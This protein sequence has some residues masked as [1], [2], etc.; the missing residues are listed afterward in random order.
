MTPVSKDKKLASILVVSTDLPLDDMLSSILTEQGYHVELANTTNE[1]M[2]KT[3]QN[4]YDLVLLDLAAP[5]M[6]PLPTLESLTQ[7]FPRLPVVV[8]VYSHTELQQRVELIK[9]G[10]FD[11]L[12][13]P[14]QWHELKVV[15]QRTQVVIRLKGHAEKISRRLHKS[16]EYFKS[17]VQA[18]P[19][20]MVLGDEGGTILSWNEAAQH[21][22]GYTAKEIIGQP[23]TRLMP[24]RYHQAHQQG[25]AR[26]STT[27]NT[28]VIGHTVE[29]EALRR[30]G[31]EFP[32]ELSLSYSHVEDKIFY[33]GIIRDITERKEA[34]KALLERNRMLALDADV[35]QI[36]SR[37][38]EL[39]PLLQACAEA[40]LRHLDVAFARIW[41]LEHKEQVLA[42]KAS[43]GL[44]THL[45]GL[46]SR[47][48]IGYLK[49]GKIAAE[50]KPILTNSV[51]GDPRIPD[52]EWAK[53][54]EL[55]AFAGYPL[56]RGQE[57]VGVMALFAKHP[58]TEFTL[59]SLEMVADRITTAVEFQRATEVNQKL[60]N[61]NEQI[62]AS[63]GEGIFGLSPQGTITFV[64]PAGANML[65][66]QADEM[67]DLE[68]HTSIHPTNHEGASCLIEGCPL[69][70]VVT[71][72]ASQHDD[73]EVFCRKNG[74]SFPVEYTAT[75]MWEDG[76]VTG[77]VVIFKDISLRKLAEEAQERFCQQIGATLA[78]LPGSILVVDRAQK[79]LYAN[80]KAQQ[81]FGEHY[82]S[83]IGC[84]IHEVLPFTP[85]EWA[86]LEEEFSRRR[87]ADE[88]HLQDL[89]FEIGDRTYAYCLFPISLEGW[90]I[91]ET[92]IVIWNVTER[93][94]LQ[95]QLIQSEKLSSLG[96]LVS[97]MVHEV[98]SPMQSIVG[99]TDLI[100]QEEDPQ[101]IQEFAGDLKRV[102]AHINTVLTDFMTYARPSAH[103]Q[104]SEVNLN[105]R[106]SEALKMV[107]RGP[108]FGKVEVTQQFSS[109]P[110]VSVRQGEIDQ[111]LI[112]LMGN[113]VQAM[114]GKG[115]L[116]LATFHKDNL[117]TA[118]ISDTGCGMPKE[119]LHKIFDPFFSTKG[120]GKG[121]GLGLSIVQQIV[122]RCGGQI[123][124]ESE[125]GKG[126]TFTIQLPGSS[127]S[128]GGDMG[129]V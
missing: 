21:M 70:A 2:R 50:K 40:L 45:D 62:L 119:I 88:E 113:A 104:S 66:Y 82:P 56:L 4:G 89:E 67:R 97:G 100:L 116:T 61:F 35:G 112:N 105:E 26:V 27:H 126:T 91:S 99:Y 65:G 107:Q 111:V 52:Q 98:R 124:V 44:Y 108:T 58:L 57:V 121:T 46:H 29:L 14:Y 73:R 85:A 101:A 71:D 55:V 37:K 11:L 3:S 90:D 48:P 38:Q 19:D 76:Q 36:I 47:I 33:C 12:T 118:Q 102:C 92:G 125:V 122:K 127:I 23:L 60:A 32:I 17:V 69:L 74:T 110:S 115:R 117:V 109:L 123:S 75:P 95:D 22:F 87:N 18:S 64:N 68:I 96:T 86:Q 59:K 94:K 13:K 31:R 7:E 5:D 39:H 6:E 128:C 114:D 80:P 42:L 79:V 83:L 103:E 8:T 9:V 43:A 84:P 72:G 28:K 93:K 25:L 51:I 24:S 54:E 10:A 34:E 49:V 41:I 129:R 16:E 81:R 77:A 78:A 1:G 15:F 106:L 20:A 63:A 120:K 53:Q 30:D